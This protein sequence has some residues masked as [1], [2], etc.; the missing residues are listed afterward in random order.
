MTVRGAKYCEDTIEQ[1]ANKDILFKLIWQKPIRAGRRQLAHSASS[2][3]PSH[4]SRKLLLEEHKLNVRLEKIEKERRQFLQRNDSD[5]RL[6][7]LAVRASGALEKRMNNGQFLVSSDDGRFQST[8]S[9]F[10]DSLNEGAL[11]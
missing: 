10:H 1:D 3:F 5:K 11:F 4:I 2:S 7:R 9:D 8:A 6:L